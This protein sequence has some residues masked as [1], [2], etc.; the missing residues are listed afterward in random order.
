MLTTVQNLK[1]MGSIL[2]LDEEFEIR[3]LMN[4][5]AEDITVQAQT[6]QAQ[7]RYKDAEYLYRQMESASAPLDSSHDSLLKPQPGMVL[8]YEKLGNLP[9]AETLQQYRLLFLMRP[10]IGSEDAVISREAENLFRLYTLFLAR[11]EDLDVMS[12][13]RIHLTLFYRIAVLG[14]SLLNGLLFKSELWTRYDHELCLQIAI[15]V[16]STEMIRGL[17]SFGVDVNKSGDGWNSPLLSAARYGNWDGLEVLLDNNVDVGARNADFGTALHEAMKRGP[18]RKDEI[19]H[20]LIKAGVD[21]NAQDSFGR[22]AF[23][24]AVYDGPEPDE[25]VVHCL[26]EAGLNIEAED[27]NKLTALW[28]AIGRGYLTTVQ[29]LLQQGANTEVGGYTEDSALFC[30]VMHGDESIAKLLLSHGAKIQARNRTGDTPLHVAMRYG[31]AGGMVGILLKG[32][33]ST[34]ACNNVGQTPVDIVRY[35][36]QEGGIG[37]QTLLD[38]LL[39]YES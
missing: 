18:E 36:V 14:C 28:L 23:H 6:H 35:Y 5:C 10:E 1:F 24:L 11:V 27:L 26:I 37:Y 20:R 8:I 29:L 38:T 4:E 30:A 31:R 13:N 22:T 3:E 9:A 33:A 16:Q 19:I 34:A 7:G 21:V 39:A 25:K 17:I 2:D 12:T 32:G 15:R